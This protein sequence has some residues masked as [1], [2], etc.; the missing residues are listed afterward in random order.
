M[1][2]Q[3]GLCS[4]APE[5]G[6]GQGLCQSREGCGLLLRVPEQKVCRKPGSHT[7][8]LEDPSPPTKQL[9]LFPAAPAWSVC[10]TWYIYTCRDN[11]LHLLLNFLTPFGQDVG[12]ACRLGL[13]RALCSSSMLPLLG[14]RAL[15]IQGPS[16]PSR[17]HWPWLGCCPWVSPKR[18]GSL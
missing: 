1:A 7:V 11:T 16:E 17:V 10:P 8:S 14:L 6:W 15:S 4:R 3:S 18:S 2:G 5:V 13:S 12:H 9:F